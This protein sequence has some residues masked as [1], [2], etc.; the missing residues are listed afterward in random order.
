MCYSV[1]NALV[2]EH[3]RINAI[4]NTLNEELEKVQAEIAALPR[5]PASELPTDY[6]EYYDGVYPAIASEYQVEYLRLTDLEERLTERRDVHHSE[7]ASLSWDIND[8]AF[9]QSSANI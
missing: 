8:E 7:R 4:V 3:N 6:N 5:K 1:Y 9:A 2:L